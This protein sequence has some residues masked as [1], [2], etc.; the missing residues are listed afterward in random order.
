[1]ADLDAEPQLGSSDRPASERLDSWKE[2]AAYLR[3]EVRTVQRWERSEGLPVHRH[4]HEKLGT[5]YAYRSELDTWWHSRQAGIEKQEQ[6]NQ[7]VTSETPVEAPK[8][9]KQNIHVSRLVF[10]TLAVAFTITIASNY[11]QIARWIEHWRNPAPSRVRVAVLPFKNLGGDPD[12]QYFAAGLTDEMIAR[13]SQVSPQ[14]IRVVALNATYLDKPLREIGKEF[15]VG[16]VLKGSVRRAGGRVGVTGE[17]IQVQDQTEVWAQSYERDL[18]D[19]LQIQSEIARAIASAISSKLPT[20]STPAPQVDPEAYEAYLKGRYF[21]NKRTPESLTKAVQYFEHA[22]AKQPNYA[23]AHAGLADCYGLLGSVPYTALPPKAAFPKAE[24]AANR[25]LEIDP[26]LAEA[27]VSLGYAKLVYEW[28]SSGAQREFQRALQLRPDNATAHQYYAYYL[29]A[30]GHLHDAIAERKKAQELD[31]LS[32]VI[33]SALGEVLYLN[34]QFDAAIEQYQKSLEL[35]PNFAIGL[36]NLGRAYGQKGM[37]A[38]AKEI[39]HKALAAAGEDP[40]IL[41]LLAYEDAITGDSVGAKEILSRLRQLS[42]GRYVPAAYIA[43]VYEGL[44]DK[45]QAFRWL[46]RAYDERC[47]Y[48]VYLGS[49]PMGDKLRADRRYQQ[50]LNRVGLASGSVES[51]SSVRYD[52]VRHST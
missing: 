52:K 25:A 46:S 18:S 10:V 12:Q 47:D 24:A 19:V 42:A 50:L 5:V 11:G 45:D 37:H 15:Q 17:L 38:Q 20:S 43:V 44:G 29:T 9:A 41:M 49:E 4:L 8:T 16:Y 6:S 22:I 31:P 1:M 35:D 51:R 23:A 28:D 30:I 40:G 7:H 48:L 34:R 2:I 27:H 33:T 13:L 32:P 39:F 14:K 3:R 26:N 21:W 36:I